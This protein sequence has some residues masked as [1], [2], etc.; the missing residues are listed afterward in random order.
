[1]LSG[2]LSG[3]APKPAGALID[4]EG[5]RGPQA[6]DTRLWGWGPGEERRG[7]GSA[8]TGCVATDR[9]CQEAPMGTGRSQDARGQGT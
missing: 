2:A 3:G 5:T 6:L 7:R 9:D 8:H 1:M 4:N